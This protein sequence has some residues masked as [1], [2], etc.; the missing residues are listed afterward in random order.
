MYILLNI[1][2]S[3]TLLSFWYVGVLVLGLTNLMPS[4]DGFH[5]H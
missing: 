2:T 4:F 3:F 1:R 5:L